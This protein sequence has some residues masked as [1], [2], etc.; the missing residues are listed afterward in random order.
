MEK[1]F[2]N[3]DKIDDSIHSQEDFDECIY[4]G[5]DKLLS[6]KK[7]TDCLF[8]TTLDNEYASELFYFLEGNAEIVNVHDNMILHK[9]DEIMF[10]LID[11]SDEQVI[12][13]LRKDAS[14]IEEFI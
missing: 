12:V 5:V 8:C 13:C 7:Y 10:V 4:G 14:S 6:A 9:L 2:V 11:N 1:I 3:I